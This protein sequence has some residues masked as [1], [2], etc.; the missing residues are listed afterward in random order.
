M[1]IEVSE[2]VAASRLNQAKYSVFL[3]FFI[4]GFIFASWAARIPLVMELFAINSASMGLFLLCAAAGSLTALAI[5]GWVNNHFS[6]AHTVLSSAL[7]FSGGMAIVAFS[8][9][10]PSQWLLGGGLFIFGFGFSLCDVAMNLEGT[11]V[12][13]RLAY[14]I[15]PKLHAFF[16]F[17]TVTGAAFGAVLEY[18]KFGFTFPMLILV[19]VV[20]ISLVFCSRYYL[21]TAQANQ[22][23]DNGNEQ[24][25]TSPFAAWLEPRT[26]LIGFT[27]L[28]VSLLEGAA[29]DWLP[30]GVLTGFKINGEPP[31]GWM[32][33][34]ALA[35]FVTTMTTMRWFGGLLLDKY[36]RTK[37]LRVCIALSIAGLFIFGFSPDL[38]MAIPGIILWGVG[39]ALGFPVGMSAAADEPEHAA[40]RIA[41]V[42]AIGYCSLLTGPPL[43][44][45]LAN[46][47]GV[48]NALLLL[49]IPLCL[50]L[51][52]VSQL[53]AKP[54]VEQP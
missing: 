48:K 29:F 4:C 27:V 5:A 6:S 11:Q 25:R 44:G 54:A 43:L 36:G 46:S 40:S 14:S 31:A 7:I 20:G 12:E 17:G 24:T 30:L 41:V 19:S 35:L 51:M 22:Q 10:I 34:M 9:L 49:I 21:A 37:V 38:S 53:N 1:T 23:A 28:A 16:S 50:S 47:I 39:S 52:V 3:T 42:A 32:G 15:M 33:S 8:A 2:N 45:F 18:L 13:Q 26:L